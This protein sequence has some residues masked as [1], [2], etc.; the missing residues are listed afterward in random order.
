VVPN[1]LDSEEFEPNSDGVIEKNAIFWN[2]FNYF[3]PNSQVGTVGNGGLGTVEG[4]GT[5][6]YPTGIGVVLLGSTNWT[7]QNNEIFGNFKA[8]G[9][10]VS[11]PTNEGHNAIS[12]G[13]QWLNNQ[14]GRNGTDTNQVDFFSDGSGTGNCFS[15]NSSTTFDPST[16]ATNAQLYPTCPAPAGTG[17][18]GSDFGDSTQFGEVLS[19][20][21]TDPPEK[22]E[23]SWQRH[24]HPPYKGYKP[25]T[26]TP[27]PSC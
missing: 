21:T 17:G 11:D 5:I 14:M 13:N 16:T 18:N 19:Y 27:G 10:T 1:T 3:L 23:C 9:W 15:G 20:V 24:D 12:I 22:Q 6:Q 26:I 2:N 25:L 4:V 8:G 7:V